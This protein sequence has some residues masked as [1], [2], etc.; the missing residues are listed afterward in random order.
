MNQYN[1]EQFINDCRECIIECNL[2]GSC[3]EKILPLMHEL[4]KGDKKF[5]LPKHKESN[6]HHYARN[7]IYIEK[8]LFGLC[9]ASWPVDTNS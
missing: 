5:L 7:A 3:V 1:L 6:P 9:M 8:N 2:P 4:L